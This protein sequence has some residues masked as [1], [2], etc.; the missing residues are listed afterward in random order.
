MIYLSS[1]REKGLWTR[2]GLNSPPDS[3][4]VHTR[5]G[6]CGRDAPRYGGTFE[7]KEGAPGDSGAVG[8]DPSRGGSFSWL[9]VPSGLT[10]RAYNSPILKTEFLYIP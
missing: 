6:F 9:P 3:T 7:Y 1:K 2:V 10:F 5:T 4:K 8:G